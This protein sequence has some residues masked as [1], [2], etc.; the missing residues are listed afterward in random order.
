MQL[1]SIECKR[2]MEKCAIYIGQENDKKI[3]PGVIRNREGKM[4]VDRT[5]CTISLSVSL[6]SDEP[7]IGRMV[8]RHPRIEKINKRKEQ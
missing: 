5:H 3:Y 8:T 6:S 4:T 1:L 7:Y 2:R